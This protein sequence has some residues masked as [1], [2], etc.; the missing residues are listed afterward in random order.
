M[1]R[2]SFPPEAV[3]H[4]RRADPVLREVIDR[5]GP[6]EPAHEPDLWRS[7]VGSIISQQLS[8]RAA[9]TI[10]SW[11]AALGDGVGFPEPQ[12]L[13]ALPE[14]TLRACGLSGAK[15][16]YVKDLA[17]KWLDGTLQPERIAALPD[18]EV[19]AELTRVKGIGRW[20]AEMVLIFT[21]RRPDVLPVDDLGFRNA[22]QRAYGLPERPGA[23]ELQRLGDAWRPYR[24][25]ATLYL[26]RSLK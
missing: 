12:R 1:S 10:E 4:L 2:G 17:G 9:A 8:V 24:S 21:L 6:F 5:V 23:A 25:I 7:L 22:V 18:E 16:R 13:L 11:V 19:I 26:W 14:E 20:T 3:D 15:T